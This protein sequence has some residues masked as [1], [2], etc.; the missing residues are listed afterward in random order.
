MRIMMETGVG[1]LAAEGHCS[2]WSRQS[3]LNVT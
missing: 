3:I 1:D 2:I